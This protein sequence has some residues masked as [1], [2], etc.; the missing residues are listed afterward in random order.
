MGFSRISLHKA[1]V[2]FVNCCFPSRAAA[3]RRLRATIT[4]L[5]QHNRFCIVRVDATYP[6][7]ALSL[8]PIPQ[9]TVRKCSTFA[10]ID[11]ASVSALSR[12]QKTFRSRRS[13]PRGYQQVVSIVNRCEASA[14]LALA[15]SFNQLR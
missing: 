6:P 1:I 2:N 5:L 3:S 10:Q 4:M 15:G 13:H 14:D 11:C 8:Q 9:R 12:Q 7:P